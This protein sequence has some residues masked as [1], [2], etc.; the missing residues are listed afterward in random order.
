MDEGATRL[1]FGTRERFE[2]IEFRLFWEGQVNRVDIGDR[3]RVSIPQVSADIARYMSEARDNMRY[4]TRLKTY[5]AT[6]QFRPIFYKP[7]ARQYLADLRSIGDRAVTK[8]RTWL[9]KPSPYDTAPNPRRPLD[10][11]RL[12]AILEAIRSKQSIE[13]RYQSMSSADSTLRWLTPHALGYDGARWHTRAW[14]NRRHEF[15]D[16]V[17]ARVLEV[18]RTQYQPIDQEHDREWCRYVT[19]S[20][21]PR[22]ELTDGR[23]RITELEYGMNDGRL[24]ISVRLSMSYYLE[25]NL[26]LDIAPQL[27]P[28]R[29]PLILLNRD[30]VD[31]LRATTKDEQEMINHQLELAA[32]A[33]A[34]T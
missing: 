3:F 19:L 15:R 11:H 7:S 24:E 12:R 14:C 8:E 33:E 17:L 9:G 5:V 34:H 18:G 27:D 20:I 29:A 30:E 32:A 10:P 23:R 28:R 21:G 16:F 4:D 6:E 25:R 22:P 13:I 26:L 31:E 2:F 1:R